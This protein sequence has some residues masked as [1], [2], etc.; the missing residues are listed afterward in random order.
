M[1]HIH[2][3]TLPHFSV[4]MK[5]FADA[6]SYGFAFLNMGGLVTC[7]QIA[8]AHQEALFVR[9]QICRTSTIV[10]FKK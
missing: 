2:S 4:L 9:I 8:M 5:L 1:F 6:L 10:F 7:V 3:D